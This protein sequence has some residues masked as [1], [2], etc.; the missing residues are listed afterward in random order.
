VG[1]CLMKPGKKIEI[2]IPMLGSLLNRYSG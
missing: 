1:A 2:R